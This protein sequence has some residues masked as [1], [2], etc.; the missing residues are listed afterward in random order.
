MATIKNKLKDISC[1]NLC[2]ETK[3][4]ANERE[5]YREVGSRLIAKRKGMNKVIK[6]VWY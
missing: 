3:F 5:K 1:P 6:W 2:N 4:T